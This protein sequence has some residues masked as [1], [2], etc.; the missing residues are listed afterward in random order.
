[1][2]F[3]VDFSYKKKNP[4]FNKLNI[5]IPDD[6]I[7]VICGHNGAGKT[8]LLKLMAGVLPDKEKRYGWYVPSS[9]G[10]IKHFSLKEHL[11]IIG[12]KNSLSEKAIETFE[13][14]SFMNRKV[15]DLST[16]QYMLASFVVA[17]ASFPKFIL[18]DEPFGCLDP[19]NA[20][21]LCEFLKEMK[22]KEITIVITS[23]D[24][25]LTNELADKIIFLKNGII[26]WE[27]EIIKDN[28]YNVDMLREKYELY[29]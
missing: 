11:E 5:D 4:I 2:E 26:S 17:F 8:T 22:L 3:T 15:E 23:H 13:L 28:L 21:L 27:E 6:K 16:G 14:S 18:L 9:G 10:L 25:Y 19:K 29:S 24:L 7:T 12:K 20:S 1:M